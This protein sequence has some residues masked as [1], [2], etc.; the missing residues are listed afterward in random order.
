MDIIQKELSLQKKA[1]QYALKNFGETDPDT[2]TSINNLAFLYESQ[3]R[4]GEAEPLY[5]RFYQLSEE[6]L[7]PKHPFTLTSINNLAELYRSQG[8]YGE[9]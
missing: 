4:Y 1:N 3:G 9:A 5:K 6:V 8:M 7:G 2:L